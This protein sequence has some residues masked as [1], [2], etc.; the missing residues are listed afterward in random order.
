MNKNNLV[1]PYKRVSVRLGSL[2]C[3]LGLLIFLIGAHP[4]WF[5]M[6]RSPVIGFVQITVFLAG[7]GLI[8]AGGYLTLSALWNGTPKSITSD[9]GV[10]LVSTGFVVAL[11]CG[12]ADIF[13][14][15]SHISPAIPYFGFWQMIGVLIGEIVI[16]IGLIMLIPF[17]MPKA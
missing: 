12:L 3:L 15:G 14:F 16:G 2:I 7:L 11:A 9:F 10:R 4:D 8:C 17:R 6:D 5:G 1:S 13:G